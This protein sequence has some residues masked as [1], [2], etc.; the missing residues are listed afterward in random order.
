MSILDYVDDYVIAVE[1]FFDAMAEISEHA[2]KG[3]QN[4]ISE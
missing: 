1:D 2:N 3:E 4:E